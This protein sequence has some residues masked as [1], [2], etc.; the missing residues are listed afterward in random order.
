MKRSAQRAWGNIYKGNVNDK[1]ALA[2][3]FIKKH[4]A[5][6][7]TDVEFQ[8]DPMTGPELKAECIHA[9]KSAGGLDHFEPADFALLSDS[10]FTKL[11][12]LLNAIED[13]ADWPEDVST[14]RAAFL[15]KGADKLE[16]PLAYRELLIMSSSIGD[17]HPVGF[18]AWPLGSKGGNSR[19]CLQGWQK[20]VPKMLGGNRHWTSKNST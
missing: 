18:G 10:A 6:I 14:A 5:S 4:A 7:Y 8:L 20:W 2:E 3:H 9:R 1:A 12:D 15:A 17:G 16:D 13:G 11:A 19:R